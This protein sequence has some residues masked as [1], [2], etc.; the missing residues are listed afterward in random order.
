MIEAF[1][2]LDTDI[3]AHENIAPGSRLTTAE[4]W[5]DHMQNMQLHVDETITEKPPMDV[6]SEIEETILDDEK[7]PASAVERERNDII[8]VKK[9][10]KCSYELVPSM[11]SK[12]IGCNH[13]SNFNSFRDRIFSACN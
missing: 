11:L 9:V 7:V 2:R 4:A 10:C 1:T 12:L 13:P 6:I 5:V 3:L 8:K